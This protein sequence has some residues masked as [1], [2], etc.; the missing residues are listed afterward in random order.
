M[1]GLGLFPV[2]WTG[3]SMKYFETTNIIPISDGW[4]FYSPAYHAALNARGI[5]NPYAEICKPNTYIVTL[6]NRWEKGM[7][8]NISSMH[9]S[10]MGLPLRYRQVDTVGRFTIWKAE[11]SN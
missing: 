3:V 11:P 10:Q 6:S 4:C 5:K 8:N 2:G 9:E 7:L 1:Q